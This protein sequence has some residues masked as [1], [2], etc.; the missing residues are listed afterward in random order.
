MTITVNWDSPEQKYL[1]ANYYSGWK[2][3]DFRKLKQETD[4]HLVSVDYL[5]DALVI[6]HDHKNADRVHRPPSTGSVDIAK[7][8]NTAPE[9]LNKIYVVNAGAIMSIIINIVQRLAPNSP[10]KNIQFIE[11]LAQATEMIENSWNA[12]QSEAKL[13]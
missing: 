5:V 12:R 7:A 13:S 6:F 2:I 9:N 1:I 8:F 10:A 4:E 3:S 11:T